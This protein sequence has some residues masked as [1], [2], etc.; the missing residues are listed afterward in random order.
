[1]KHAE[2]AFFVSNSSPKVLVTA[3]WLST[4]SSDPTAPNES[5][6]TRFKARI[7]RIKRRARDVLKVL[8]TSNI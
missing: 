6:C 2:F 1:M 3:K 4:T 7:A 5:S 8:G